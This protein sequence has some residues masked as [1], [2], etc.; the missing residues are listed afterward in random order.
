MKRI[1]VHGIGCISPAGWG[2][3]AMTEALDRGVPLAAPPL[4]R[5][6]SRRPLPFRSV[7]APTVKFPFLAHP[8]L[9]RA[10]SLTVY[11]AA[12]AVEAMAALKPSPERRLGIIFCVTGGCVQFTRRF[13]H[14]AWRETT[15]SPVVFP[16]TVFNAPSSHLSALFSSSAINYTYVGDPATVVQG[17]GT[18]AEWLE[19]NLVDACLVIGAEEN[20]WLTADAYRHFSRD[21]ICS[22]GAGA[23]LLSAEPAPIE[24]AAITDAELYLS[25]AERAQ[26]LA[27]VSAHFPASATTLLCDSQTGAAA[28]DRQEKAAWADW[29]GPRLSPKKI[30]GEGLCAGA[31]W[32]CV[33]AIQA[34][35]RIPSAIAHVAGIHEHAIAA[36]FLRAQT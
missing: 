10:S 15:A 25:A 5:P 27:E 22:E 3:A 2:V 26:A 11:A 17:L 28:R 31:A 9:R 35:S 34:L 1:F 23:I 14:E 29:P 7:P 33:A 4:Q 13:Y 32:Q 8:R 16:E 36:Q 20:D 24:L 6:G 19:D 18:A 30:L 12:A 21:T